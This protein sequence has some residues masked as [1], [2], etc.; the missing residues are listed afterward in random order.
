MRILDRHRML[1][2]AGALCALTPLALAEDAPKPGQEK[3]PELVLRV[4]DVSA[5][6]ALQTDFP[7]PDVVYSSFPDD[8]AD[9]APNPFAGAASSIQ[10]TPADLATLIQERYFPEDF[11]GGNN[12]S[13]T[14]QNGKL[15]VMQTPAVHLKIEKWLRQMRREFARRVTVQG[16]EVAVDAAEA[17]RWLGQAGKPVPNERVKAFFDKESGALVVGTPQVTAYH[18]QRAHA[19]AGQ[20]VRYTGSL[21][22]APGGYVPK[23]AIR[24][25][26]AVLDVTP[27]IEPSGREILLSLRYG[28]SQPSAAG[29]EFFEFSAATGKGEDADRK[30][31]MGR[32]ELPRLDARTI[33]T[34]LTVPA[35]AWVLA[36]T[37]D[38]VPGARKNSAEARWLLLFV[39]CEEIF[40]DSSL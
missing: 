36:A 20:T 38:P 24:N 16:L 21:A 5:L 8:G 4:F 29:H 35:S 22:E 11:A 34:S 19:F 39:R 28:R 26:G 12:A 23:L 25:E 15:V 27:L 13:I 18:R 17:V 37:M 33:R 6:T 32:I 31:A 2:A 3:E 1:L 30:A 14:D 9:A 10:V 7:G 40:G